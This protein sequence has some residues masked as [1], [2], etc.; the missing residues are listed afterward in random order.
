MNPN[1]GYATI[2]WTY[3]ANGQPT[4]AMGYDASDKPLGAVRPTILAVDKTNPLDLREG[5]IIVSYNHVPT[6]SWREL[7]DNKLNTTG[8]DRPLGIE[9]SGSQLE[10]Q[11]PPAY[12]LGI[13]VEDR[14]YPST[15]TP[16]TSEQ[17]QHGN[18]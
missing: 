8:G 2:K 7:Y 9:R 15:A 14:L 1:L 6:F 5:D 17:G 10:F 3:D 16:D 18:Q 13:S 12:Q 11:A 4:G